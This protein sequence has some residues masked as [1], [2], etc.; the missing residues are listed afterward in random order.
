M[1]RCA[2][3]F[4][5]PCSHAYV[6]TDY[7][8]NISPSNNFYTEKEKLQ[9]TLNVFVQNDLIPLFNNA[10]I[11]QLYRKIFIEKPALTKQLAELE[12][13]IAELQRTEIKLTANFDYRPILAKYDAARSGRSFIKYA[14]AVINVA[15]EF[16]D[17]LQEYTNAQEATIAEIS[18]AAR[19]IFADFDNEVK[20]TQE[21]SSQLERRQRVIAQ[22]MRPHI[23]AATEQ[24]LSA[25]TEATELL[26][27]LDEIN[28]DKESLNLLAKL[29]AEPRA[30]FELVVE[31]F[32]RTILDVQKQVDFY[33]VNKDLIAKI[34]DE[35][36]AWRE[37]Y[38][39][40]KKNLREEFL[41]ACQNDGI[42]ENLSVGWFE[43]W[44][45]KRLA[46]E[47]NFV[48]LIR[49]VFNGYLRDAFEHVLKLL[50]EFRDGLD[51]FYLHERKEIHDK[52][53][54]AAQE[55]FDTEAAIYKLAEKFQRYLQEIISSRNNAAERIFLLKWSGAVVN[56]PLDGI[57]SFLQIKQADEKLLSKFASLKRQVFLG[58]KAFDAEITRRTEKFNA[59]L[60]QAAEDVEKL[61]GQFR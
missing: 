8:N 6:P 25:R 44:Q 32:S 46:V 55:K 53:A 2:S 51:N 23:A 27:R 10:A 35:D 30:D 20:L 37:S 24:L 40:F 21:E 54:N 11:T 39:V 26:D 43:E 61:A 58:D 9:F 19:K 59:L 36:A 38:F 29:Q 15:N 48:P 52:A 4:V 42:E 49:R 45:N 5:I 57:I 56:L 60:L 31:N 34:I 7:E 28:A 22:C 47:K 33:L 3:V 41:T 1:A 17:I 18:A 14:N 12:A 50:R 16:L 13:Q